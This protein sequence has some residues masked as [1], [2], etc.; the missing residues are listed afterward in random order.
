M[1]RMLLNCWLLNVLKVKQMNNESDFFDPSII[2]QISNTI[3]KRYLCKHFANISKSDV[4]VLFF[5]FYLKQKESV[6]KKSGEDSYLKSF[7][8]DYQIS[9]ELGITQSK[10][11]SLREKEY[12]LF[13]RE[14]KKEQWKDDFIKCLNEYKERGS[15]KKSCIQYNSTNLLIEMSVPDINVLIEARNYLESVGFYDEVV[16]NKHLFKCPLNAFIVLCEYVDKDKELL[17]P[18]KINLF[19][20]ELKKLDPSSKE[21]LMEKIQSL[22]QDVIL[23]VTKMGVV[24]AMCILGEMLYLWAQS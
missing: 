3:H 17:V 23:D 10:V 15:D 16:L 9:N 2:V 13:S 4:E 20:Q 6:V 5:H 24:S 14:S 21:K 22:G 12:I 19:V 1:C 18:E 7:I 11:R 8:T